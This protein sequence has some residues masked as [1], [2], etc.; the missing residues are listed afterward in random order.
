MELAI[1][2]VF[3]SIVAGVIASKKGRSALGFFLLALILSPI[4]GVIAALIV[5]E[6]R[7]S[8]EKKQI[9]SGE[10]KRC[11]YCAEIIKKEALVCRYCGKNV[12]LLSEDQGLPVSSSSK[13]LR[14]PQPPPNRA[15][16]L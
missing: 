13:N 11:S 1:L 10:S 5:S 6:D 2:W 16:P 9:E 3:F 8:V 4:I 14:P 15:P 12:D 7:A